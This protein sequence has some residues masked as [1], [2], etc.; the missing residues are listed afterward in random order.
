MRLVA[1]VRRDHA[2]ELVGAVFRVQVLQNEVPYYTEEE[3]R[4]RSFLC[5]EQQ[6]AAAWRLGDVDE[7]LE[8]I[9]A[10]LWYGG[11]VPPAD[12]PSDLD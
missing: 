12:P 5:D 11:A 6:N 10:P 2:S 9:E 1:A 3:D 4:L 7:L 8:S